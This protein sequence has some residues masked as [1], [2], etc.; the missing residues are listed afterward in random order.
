MDGQ[1][2]DYRNSFQTG[3]EISGLDFINNRYYW[4]QRELQYF[5]ETYGGIFP[6]SWKMQELI[7]E[8]FCIATRLAI[9]SL[10]ETT[11]ATLD[12]VALVRAIERTI[13]FERALCER[14]REVGG[15]RPSQQVYE[16]DEDKATTERAEE[17]DTAT[18]GGFDK[19]TLQRKW[20]VHQQNMEKEEAQ[21]QIQMLQKQQDEISDSVAG[22]RPT[23]KFKGII[24]SC[25]DPYMDLYIAQEDRNM[26][27]MLEHLISEETWTVPEDEQNKVI[28]F[29]CV[30]IVSNT[31]KVLSSSTDVIYYF[32]EARKRCS[33]LTRGQ[34]FFD[35]F[36]LFK[37][38]LAYYASVLAYRLPAYVLYLHEICF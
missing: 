33:K 5:D 24:S 10:L 21:R 20:R 35:L 6:H 28:N 31:S 15:R 19:E 30:S 38:Y 29:F 13:E 26:K 2:Q 14:F 12:V 3:I 36:G 9:S 25:F 27:E 16:E 23:T 22:G 8:E 34:P 11:K 4:L 17:E 37:K 1:L 18:G 7:A 32:N